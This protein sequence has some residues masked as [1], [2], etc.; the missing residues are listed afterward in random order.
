LAK[1][2]K[3]PL[4]R[5]ALY[6]ALGELGAGSGTPALTSCLVEETR[7]ELRSDCVTALGMIGQES[8]LPIRICLQDSSILKVTVNG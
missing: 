4:V 8:T 1:P 3:N 2:E 6:A 5:S 7:E